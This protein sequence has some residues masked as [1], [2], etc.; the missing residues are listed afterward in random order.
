MSDCRYRYTNKHGATTNEMNEGSTYRR[1]GSPMNERTMHVKRCAH[2]WI[3][4]QIFFSQIDGRVNMQDILTNEWMDE[5]MNMHLSRIDEPVNPSNIQVRSNVP[6]KL[7]ANQKWLKTPSLFPCEGEVVIHHEDIHHPA[8]LQLDMQSNSSMNVP[9]LSCRAMSQV[10]L[11]TSPLWAMFSNQCN[12]TWKSNG[13][14]CCTKSHVKLKS[15]GSQIVKRIVEQPQGSVSPLAI[16]TP[17]FL[18][19]KEFFTSAPPT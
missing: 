15:H 12:V 17:S 8:A 13:P 16:N 1:I 10:M 18:H 2:E 7:Q 3:I 9:T 11:S 4:M 5:Q 19:E 14:T 6:K